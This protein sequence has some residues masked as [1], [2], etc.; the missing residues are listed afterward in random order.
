MATFPNRRGRT[1][2]NTSLQREIPWTLTAKLEWRHFTFVFNIFLLV[3]IGATKQSAPPIDLREIPAHL[4]RFQRSPRLA[5]LLGVQACFGQLVM[6]LATVCSTWVAVNAG[7]SRRSILVP[8][9]CVS[10]TATRKGN[11]MAVRSGVACKLG[12]N[13]SQCVCLSWVSFLV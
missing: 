5:V 3:P 8:Q 2:R 9:G 13:Y 10:G 4:P 11:K 7:T 12:L 1:K 6:V